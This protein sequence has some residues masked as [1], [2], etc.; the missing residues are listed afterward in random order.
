MTVPRATRA[1][2]CLALLIVTPCLLLRSETG[3][4][5]PATA[6][7]EDDLPADLHLQWVRQLPPLKPAW[8]DQPKLPF[9][10]AYE[11]VPVGNFVLV[12]SSRTDDVTAYDARSGAE[13]WRFQADGPV[14]FAPVVWEDRAYFVADGG[15]LYCID[16]EHGDLSWKFR[17]G[18]N[19][20]RVL[21][22]ERLISMWPARGAPV[23]ADGTVYFAAGVWPFMGIFLHALDAR[24]G[25]V[26]W[27]NDGDG[28]L[29]IKQPHQADAFAGVAPQGRLV[30]TGDKLLVPGGRS[31]PACYDRHTG[32]L[33]HFRLADSSK[34]GESHRVQ[35]N[36]RLFLSGTG[37]FALDNG[38]YLGTVN[39]ASVLGDK[40][41]YS[42]SANDCAVYNLDDAVRAADVAVDPK[43]EKVTLKKWS[44]EKAVAVPT[45]PIERLIKVGN[46]LYAGSP[47]A[48]F[49]LPLP[50]REKPAA[51]SW[52]AAVEGQPVHLT[53]GNAR[54][55]VSTREGSIYCFGKDDARP[56]TY[57]TPAPPTAVVDAWTHRTRELL[58]TTGVRDGYAVVW[59][60]GS[61]R[62]VAE[63]VRQSALRVVV[64]EPDADRVQS[65]RAQLVAADVPGER[66]TVLPGE[67]ASVA[68]PPYLA[69][70]V[71]AEEAPPTALHGPDDWLPAVYAA[72]RPYGGV[73]CLPLP[74]HYRGKIEA[75]LADQARY[76][77]AKQRH[78][79]GW[80]LVARE[81][82]LP[83]AANWTHE[84]ADAANTRVSRDTIVKAPLGLLWF[85]GPSNEGILPRHGHGP[86][87]QVIDGRLLI[88]GVDKLRAI[89]IYTGRLLWETSLP[90]LGKIYDNFAHQPGANAGGSNYVSTP[91]GI[92]VL[93][94]KACVRL[95]PATG[96]RQS[97]F[98]LPNLP[99][100]KSAPNWCCLN[101]EGDYLIGGAN[102]TVDDGKGKANSSCKY[103][104]ALNRNTGKLLWR[105]TAEAG[106]R[107]NTLCLGGGHCYVIDR[108]S[109]DH[110]ALLKR[111]GEAPTS[112][113]K[114]VAFGLATGKK[115]W[116]AD[117]D[118]FGTWLSYSAQYDVLVEAG[119][120]AR[121][122]LTDEPKG[123]R[124]YRGGDGKVLWNRPDYVG[125]AMLHGDTVLKDK[126]ACDLLTGAPRLRLDPLTGEKQEWVW[127]RNYGCNTPLAS[128]N[129][130]TFR[131]GAAGYFDLCNDGGTGNFGGF[132]SSCTN[133]LIVAG[134]LITAPDY[135]RGCVCS[136]QNQSSLALVPMP[137][138]EMWTFYGA[139]EVKGAIRRVGINLGAPGNRKD[140]D[141][142][143]WLEH[144]SAGGPSPR[145]TIATV[146]AKPEVF[147]R[148]AAL[149][150]GDGPNWAAASGLRGLESL[151]V[152]LDR[153]ATKERLYT[154]RLHFMEP[155]ALEVG[156]R[157]FHVAL[158]GKPVL[159]N[160]DILHE[161]GKP[162]RS[163]VKEFKG[164]AVIKGLTIALTPTDETRVRAPVLCSVEIVAEG[165]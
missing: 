95:D 66:V 61:G 36:G 120:V 108:P 12:G 162:L 35:A 155:D 130:L 7:A 29:Y 69:S 126:S 85:G 165:W 164:V 74:D 80:T 105:A 109:A 125:P 54:L 32:K 115:L 119:R 57:R 4:A 26:V 45:P 27:T 147:R 70:L 50:L 136:Y 18:P 101:V 104:F 123:M 124:A 15:F 11:P 138:A 5:R 16:A 133:N 163:V 38:N 8:P 68:L 21:G 51:V 112:K 2:A 17:G 86:E 42:G 146:P 53:A 118:V 73:L 82:A 58:R 97:E 148:H 100:E 1:L 63:L 59:G 157:R 30:V 81:G 159:Q 33:L 65:F 106:F 90:A 47:G 98:V 9:D 76:P 20:R 41:L 40:L 156:D 139:R 39:E 55:F 137:E 23:V 140:A 91:D 103:L 31:A 37:A 46:R 77:Q 10:E 19:D 52:H 44:L 121:D 127:T 3:P 79:A 144:P 134:G 135:T 151:T 60:V 102:P 75:A 96:L 62:L 107:N 25:R 71:T 113:P 154:V 116:T 72:L 149:V 160:F 22:N 88:E 161:T 128:E 24:T 152:T 110:V 6:T 153:D 94:G 117:A 158:Q 142:T 132:R 13:V 89:D 48:V 145:L 67:P 93:T 141:G 78:V 150:A 143:L 92:Y 99:G 129:L 14:R 131:S 87:P 64:L 83:G 114:L 84:H 28:S 49:A 34:R 111:R 122:T 56:R 43:G